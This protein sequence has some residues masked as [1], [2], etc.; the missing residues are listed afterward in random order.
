MADPILDA[1]Q[2]V[3]GFF[4]ISGPLA[5]ISI[6]DQMI[7]GQWLVER[8]LEQGRIAPVPSEGLP[9]SEMPLVIIGAGAAGVTAALTAVKDRV[10][11]LVIERSSAP[12]G[13]QTASATR[14]IDP[15]QYDWPAASWA[16]STY[17][18]IGTTP[19]P[20]IAARAKLLALHWSVVWQR[21]LLRNRGFLQVRYR[22]RVVGIRPIYP[23]G[24][25]VPY[26]DLT[27]SDGSKISA[28]AFI[29][30]AGFGAE[31]CEILN[32]R[33]PG[34]PVKFR[35]VPF[36]GN[37]ALEKPGCGIGGSNPR[38]AILGGGDGAIQDALRALTKQKSVRDIYSSLKLPPDF[39]RDVLE[40]E[41]RAH[42]HWIWAGQ[43][44]RRDHAVHESLDRV[45]RN[46]ALRA[47][48]MPE[49]RSEAEALIKHPNEEVAVLHRCGHLSCFYGLNRFLAH[50][51]DLVLQQ[52]LSRSL[53]VKDS[54][55][56][57][58]NKSGTGWQ[59]EVVDHPLCYMPVPIGNIPRP[60][61]ADHIVVRYGIDSSVVL[62][63]WPAGIA[64]P[65]NRHSLVNNPTPF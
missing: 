57:D 43:N 17:P 27:L 19:L 7:R 29:W 62:P 5:P 28:Q 52:K 22:T 3:P 56:V 11:A 6:R 51:F 30:A 34:K 4:V 20:Y 61:Q 21:E 24:S 40:V 37:D 18:P 58:A 42:R 36:W 9:D 2:V 65:R 35:G 14:W 45:H 39:G 8:L 47:L 23:A 63:P 10:R 38:I 54:S 64:L 49:V 15:M 31:R 26:F 13:R 46:A 41:E 50:L 12:F 53:L 44:G 1:H 33:L 32:L 25:T 59:L 48:S 60:E 16:G 55:V